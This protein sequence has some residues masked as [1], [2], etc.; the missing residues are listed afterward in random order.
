MTHKKNDPP[1]GT[2]G[3]RD[4]ISECSPK[5]PF[6]NST[7][8]SFLQ[9]ARV[10]DFTAARRMR[11]I[12]TIFTAQQI[13]YYFDENDLPRDR[14]AFVDCDEEAE[15]VEF[16]YSLLDCSQVLEICDGDADEATKFVE[17]QYRDELAMAR[18]IDKREFRCVET[19]D[20]R[21]VK[22]FTLA[23]HDGDAA[24]HEKV[25]AEAKTFLAAIAQEFGIT[26]LGRAAR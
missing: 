1:A 19:V 17:S 24:Y 10:L 23:H 5:M 4:V 8:A 6:E 3:C 20:G 22:E 18:A 13:R 11:E 15:F 14:S 12:K 21:T 9:D 16:A 26:A 7:R 2:G 25:F